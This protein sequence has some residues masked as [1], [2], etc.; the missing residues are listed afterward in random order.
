MSAAAYHRLFGRPALVRDADGRVVPSDPDPRPY[1]ERAE[2]E[3]RRQMAPVRE[4]PRTYRRLM[5]WVPAGCSDGD[6]L[7]AVED[8][9][10]NAAGLGPVSKQGRAGMV[11][12]VVAWA[13]VNTSLARRCI[14]SV[15]L[16]S[17]S[18]AV[19]VEALRDDLL[20]HHA[21][22]LGQPPSPSHA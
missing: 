22:A 6:F 12:R 1:A 15:G 10:R 21:E 7:A 4:C 9:F 3:V 17:M 2:A 8:Y 20:D 13:T 19:W 14:P 18:D 16:P 5:P 11:S